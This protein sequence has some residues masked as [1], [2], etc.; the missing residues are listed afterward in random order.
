M[1]KKK[2]FGPLELTAGTA[3]V[4]ISQFLPWG[5]LRTTPT[6]SLG[7]TE[8][9]PFP[10]MSL[11]L[12]MNGWNGTATL[13]GVAAPNWLTLLLAAAAATIGYLTYIESIRPARWLAPALCLV[14][15]F[16]A[17][18][19]FAVLATSGK[20]TPGLGP[21]CAALCLFALVVTTSRLGSVST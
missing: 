9:N 21:L 2:R 5:E 3:G 18:A 11:S 1:E 10:G 12:T 14:G 4:F 15:I 8:M 16:Q 6:L 7:G 13:L 19:T 17:L 20:S